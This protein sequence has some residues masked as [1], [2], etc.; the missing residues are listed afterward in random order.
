MSL[1]EVITRLEAELATLDN[2]RTRLM[3][4]LAA[5]RGDAPTPPP[6]AKTATAVRQARPS[7]A[8]DAD[9]TALLSA[10][11]TA[12]APVSLPAIERSAKTGLAAKTVRKRLDALVRSG[13]V[14][15]SGTGSGTRYS[16]TN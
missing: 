13:L 1:T 3:T 15:M 5:L 6:V 8:L 16:A 12:K 10:V 2:D 9:H 14:T 11:R 4:A 7:Q